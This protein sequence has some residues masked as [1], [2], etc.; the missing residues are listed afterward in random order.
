[1]SVL[2][3]ILRAVCLETTGLWE[4]DMWI[5]VTASSDTVAREIE[6]LFLD[7]GMDGGSGGG[8]KTSKVVYTY[9]KTSSTKL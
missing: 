8:D 5:Y 1:M 2:P 4:D 9:K 3:R 6:Q 7:A